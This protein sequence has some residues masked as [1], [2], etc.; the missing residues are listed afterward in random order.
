MNRHMTLTTA[1]NFRA[2]FPL[3][4]PTLGEALLSA[5]YPSDV[6][7]AFQAAKKLINIDGFIPRLSGF[8]L[9]IINSKKFPKK[10]SNTQITFLADS[11]GAD[12]LV[13]ARRSRE[14]CAEERAIVKHT[15][16]RR[17]FY[18]ECTCKY[19]G[20]ALHGA[21]PK[22]GATEMSDELTQEEENEW[23]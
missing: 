6:T 9:D 3:A 19:Q 12:G 10:R 11:L 7:A 23:L 14:I 13:S 17:E 4:W 2:V 5:K 15:I 22:C 1:N 21:C 16:I 8:I 18:I 20:P